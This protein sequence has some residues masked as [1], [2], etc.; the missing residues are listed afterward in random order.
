MHLIFILEMLMVKVFNGVFLSVVTV[1]SV[2]AGRP[3]E[4]DEIQR[5]RSASLSASMSALRNQASSPVEGNRTSSTLRVRSDGDRDYQIEALTRSL[6]SLDLS[7]D[8]PVG[9]KLNT[10]LDGDVESVEL[11]VVRDINAMQED[12]AVTTHARPMQRQSDDDDNAS[13]DIPAFPSDYP[14]VD[15]EDPADSRPVSGESEDEGSYDQ[16]IES[17]NHSP[18]TSS[19]SSIDLSRL[20]LGADGEVH[21]IDDFVPGPLVQ[22]VLQMMQTG[23]LT[24]GLPTASSNAEAGMVGNRPI[25]QNLPSNT[26]RRNRDAYENHAASDDESDDEQTVDNDENDENIPLQNKRAR[27]WAST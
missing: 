24:F 22:A 10:S 14:Q 16:I 5:P 19:V 11:D 21:D 12:Q 6:A 20:V 1:T 7:V 8:R 23:R 25:L 9:N 13:N 27:R 4:G 2:M 3:G 18:S 15:D 17:P 26:G